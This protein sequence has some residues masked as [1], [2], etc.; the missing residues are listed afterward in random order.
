MGSEKPIRYHGSVVER[1]AGINPGETRAGEE[2][3]DACRALLKSTRRLSVR[4]GQL[5]SV[6]RDFVGG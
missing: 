4:S 1:S 6:P 5:Q 3:S 2:L